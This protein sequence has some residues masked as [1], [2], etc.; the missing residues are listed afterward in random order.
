MIVAEDTTPSP[1]DES[2]IPALPT[3]DVPTDTPSG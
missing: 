2:E 3:E 1:D